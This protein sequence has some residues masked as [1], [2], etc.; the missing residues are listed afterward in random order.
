MPLEW[1][2]PIA[3]SCKDLGCLNRGPD[4]SM[5]EATSHKADERLRIAYGVLGLVP[6][7]E[8]A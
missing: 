7:V 3:R 1:V 6:G 5:Y 8:R 4:D 2:A